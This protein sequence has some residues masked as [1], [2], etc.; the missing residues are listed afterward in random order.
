MYQLLSL[1][2]FVLWCISKEQY[3]I[4]AAVGFGVVDVACGYVLNR[5]RKGEK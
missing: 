5:F 2:L 3:I 4:W 1:V